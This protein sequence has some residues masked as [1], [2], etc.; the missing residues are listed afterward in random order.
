MKFDILVP[1]YKE[2]D[3]VIKPLL[4]SIALQQLVDFRDIGVIIVNDGSDVHLSD[5][6]I[7]SYPFKI[8]YIL[9]EHGGVSAAR[10]KALDASTADYVM[11]CDADDM[12]Y[13][14]T[15]LWFVFQQIKIHSFDTLVSVFLEETKM[16][17]GEHFYIDRQMDST[18]VHGKVHRRRYLLEQNI[19]WNPDL[20]IHEDSYF[21]ILCQKC[22]SPDKAIYCP[23]PFYL[24]KWR[25]ESVCR[26][27]FKYILKT[28]NNM[29][30]SNTALVKEL[31][32]RRKEQDAAFYVVNMVYDAYFTMNK[33]EWIHQENKEYRDATEKRFSEYYKNFKNRFE[34]VPKEQHG[35]VLQGLRNRFYQEGMFLEK[36]TFDQWIEHIEKLI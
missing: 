27:D 34:S 1:Q 20:T 26:N 17:N 11:F 21:N 22:A 29:L 33:D 3:E 24:W 14:M 15:G 36:Q 10:Q 19:R 5:E 31:I 12:F 25:D 23:M 6:L 28:Y 18:F 16:P 4:D 13:N 32:S 35:Q 2:T 30:D 8:Q 9:S 7:N